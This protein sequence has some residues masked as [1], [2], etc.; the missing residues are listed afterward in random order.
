LTDN[1]KDWLGIHATR[2]NGHLLRTIFRNIA[3]VKLVTNPILGKI[4]F[5]KSIVVGAGWKP[6]WSTD[7]VANKIAERFNIPVVLNLSNIVQ[8]YTEDP[9]KNILAKPM[10]DMLWNDYC[11]LVGNKWIPGMNVPYDPIAANLALKTNTSVL[12]MSGGN[13][14]NLQNC[15]EGKEFIGTILHN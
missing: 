8:V 5:D 9:K 7:F 3:Q 11:N 2:F 13:L 14:S 6:G 1:D 15:L 4:D 12:V 10:E